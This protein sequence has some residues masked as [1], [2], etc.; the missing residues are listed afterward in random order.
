MPAVGERRKLTDFGCAVLLGT[1]TASG[2]SSEGLARLRAQARTLR[3]GR[4]RRRGRVDLPRGDRVEHVLRLEADPFDGGAPFLVAWGAMPPGGGEP[5]R[6]TVR[7]V[8]DRPSREAAFRDLLDDLQAGDARRDPIYHFG[9]ASARAF[10]RLADETGLSPAVQGRLE[11]R[12]VDLAPRVRRAMVLPAHFYGFCEVAP[13]ARGD[14]APDPWQ[15]PPAPFLEVVLA[16]G[17]ASAERDLARDAE[18]S[19]R[20]LAGIRAWIEGGPERGRP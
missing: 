19:V 8:R 3:E 9:G 5:D 2:V 20:D 4:P 10:D 15:P 1:S 12:L 13:L 18:R 14:A 6:V 16:D 17:D 7:I 11:A